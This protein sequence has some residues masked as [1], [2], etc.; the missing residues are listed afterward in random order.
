MSHASRTRPGLRGASWPGRVPPVQ[1]GVDERPDVDAIDRHVHDLAVDVDVDHLDA[2][3]HD[4]AQVDGA[5][6]GTGHIDGTQLR[7]AEVD[8]LEPGATQIGL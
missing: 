4:P 3:H 6:L 5:E 8:A 7:A 2:P 1:L